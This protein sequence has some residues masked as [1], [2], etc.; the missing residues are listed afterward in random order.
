MINTENNNVPEFLS[1]SFSVL[2]VML[3]FMVT[4]FIILTYCN[5]LLPVQLTLIIQLGSTQTKL[6]PT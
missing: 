1:W 2:L 4:V 6:N 5:L 3:Y